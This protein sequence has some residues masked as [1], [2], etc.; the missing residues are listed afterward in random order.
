M[1]LSVVLSIS[2]AAETSSRSQRSGQLLAELLKVEVPQAPSPPVEFETAISDYAIL[3]DSSYFMI[4]FY[5]FHPDTEVI[6]PPL[7]VLLL[8]K[9]N[10]SWKHL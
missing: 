8:D 2:G 6:L 4:G 7:Q 10:N 1:L 3:S 9:K 5:R